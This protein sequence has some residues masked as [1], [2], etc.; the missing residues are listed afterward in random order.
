MQTT[1]AILTTQEIARR[2]S[3]LFNENKW[4]QAQNELF[5]EK[6][7]SVEPNHQPGLETVEG[8]EAIKKKTSD[9]NNGI[10]EVHSGYVTEPIVA[11][12][13]I[14]FGM[15]M[16]ATLKAGNRIKIDEVAVYEVRDGKIIREQFFY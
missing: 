12:R 7:L 4:E 2:L 13:H 15:G 3:E 5:D 16:D 10:A 8:L 6:A 14:S 1:E 9:F 11:G